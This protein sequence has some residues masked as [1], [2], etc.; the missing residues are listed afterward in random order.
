MFDETNARFCSERNFRSSVQK[1]GAKV[2][3]KAQDEVLLTQV[4]ATIPSEVAHKKS[5]LQYSLTTAHLCLSA[6]RQTYI[7]LATSQLGKFC[8]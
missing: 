1:L 2:G 5:L 3:N 6:P 4:W 8:E 7:L